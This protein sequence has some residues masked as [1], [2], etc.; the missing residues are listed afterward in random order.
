MK[1]KYTKLI[2]I[3]VAL[4]LML[5][6]SCS[7]EEEYV[8]TPAT[9][10][11][12]GFITFRLQGKKQPVSYATIATA[13]ENAVDS[14]EIY[15]F[16]D[17]SADSQP[18]LLQKVFRVGGTD[19]NQQG[20]DLETTVDVTGRTGKHIFYFV[21]NGKD[22]ASSLTNI[23]AGA[24]TEAD[25]LERLS[26][27]QSGLLKTPLLMTARKI[28][29]D[30]ENAQ[31]DDLKV[32]LM[33][34]V[35]RFDVAN[36]AA[37]TNFTVENI[38]IENVKLQGYAFED[39]T[40]I[41][42]PSLAT[43]TL[44]LINYAGE[45]NAN[46]A[47][48]IE[49]LFY[50]YPTE[51]GD[52]KSIISFEGI[53]MG[54]RRIYS[55]KSD[56]VIEANKRYTL[57]V[58]TVDVNTPS[59]ILEKEDWGEDNGE[60]ITEAEARAML[61]G[62]AELTG[63]NDIVE[64]GRTYDITNATSTGVVT[65]PVTSYTK[66]GT[67]ME[68]TYLHGTG[69]SDSKVTFNNPKPVLTY[70][71]GYFQEYKVNL[72]KPGKTPMHARVEIINNSRPEIRDTIYVKSVPNYDTT[73]EKPVLFGGIYWAP[74]NVG[75]TE[76]GNSVELKHTGY[77]YQ[78]GRN[79]GFVYNGEKVSTSDVYA[80]VG[81]VS[82]EVATEGDAAGL[83]VIS[84]RD[85]SDWLSPK[86]D[87]LWS[88]DNRQGPCPDGWRVPNLNE[89]ILIES[90]YGSGDIVTWDETENS[91]QIKGDNETDILYFPAAGLRNYSNGIS[92]FQGSKGRYWSYSTNKT[93]A[94]CLDFN[95]SVVKG[96]NDFRANGLSVRCVQD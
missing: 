1:T 4:V 38:I 3:L 28:I 31:G 83:F 50:L 41:S 44:P 65:I 24:T 85:I 58:K 13:N 25:F 71:A 2:M 46:T 88:N 29:A 18:N 68:V 22:N 95:S 67:R 75:A 33:R 42:A 61:V 53:F 91:I 51:I 92:Y 90:A 70:A 23:N 19:L 78:W 40:G 79:T 93:L 64:A 9:P 17:R 45:T 77:Y 26:D 48:P 55:L 94:I 86:D 69:N 89:I 66:S 36:N 74:L 60:Y 47:T 52:G 59:V 34:R 72:P 16:N 73:N 96:A 5:A 81:P 8:D 6:P 43:G 80:T 11:R 57:R 30:V 63:G 87:S 7:N 35:A 12:E 32:K 14:I 49:S 21:A 39:A 20:T 84:T 56:Q 15:M 54:E 27:V 62:A 37:Q 10:A 82:W 76:I